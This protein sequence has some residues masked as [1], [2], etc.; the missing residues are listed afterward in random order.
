MNWGYNPFFF[1]INEAVQQFKNGRKR[2][3][4]RASNPKRSDFFSAK[5][6]CETASNLTKNIMIL[7]ILLIMYA[8]FV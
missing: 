7:H 2:R 6:N 1:I 4:N 8:H 3:A 5:S